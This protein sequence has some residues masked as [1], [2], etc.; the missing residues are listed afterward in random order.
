MRGCL[1]KG[2]VGCLG[3]STGCLVVLALLMPFACG[4]VLEQS[5]EEKFAATHLG[6]L[7]IGEARLGTLL[8]EQG[9]RDVELLDP[10]G[11]L[12]LRGD[13]FLP[14]VALLLDF[15]RGRVPVRLALERVSFVEV[16]LPDGGR[17]TTL[18]QALTLRQPARIPKPDSGARGKAHGT[19]SE[20]Q[21]ADGET[22]APQDFHMRI[23]SDDFGL[24]GAVEFELRGTANLVDWYALGSQG[25]PTLFLMVGK[26]TGSLRSP[27]DD[28]IILL[29][30]RG[31]LRT[32]APLD[33]PV[34]LTARARYVLPEHRP[35]GTPF[36]PW[37]TELTIELDGGPPDLI[38]ELDHALTVITG[39]R[40]QREDEGLRWSMT[41]AE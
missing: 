5:L 10:S 35:Q 2:P 34:H 19:G 7:S 23:S 21:T 41:A 3:F 40:L 9:L 6:S 11:A 4:R 16:D 14:P 17:T 37:P 22:D 15:E 36:N 32:I 12:L 20:T 13:L 33:S 27:G 8:V 25:V 38:E 26:L 39:G 24:Q 28:R 29:E 1:W 18:H 31:K 30:M